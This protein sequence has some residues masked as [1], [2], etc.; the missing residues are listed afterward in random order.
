M[1]RLARGVDHGVADHVGHLVLRQ[2]DAWE[3]NDA[4]KLLADWDPDGILLAPGHAVAVADLAA[5][6]AELHRTHADLRIEMTN[7]IAAPDGRRFALEWD[8]AI[9]ELATR[10]R[11]ITKD[12]IVV[13]LSA[14][15]LIRSWR[16]Y[17]DPANPATYVGTDDRGSG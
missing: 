12:A 8:W 3:T 15:G 9:T 7:L 11:K 4:Q 2:A 13:D 16:E 17:F 6:L 10:R 5:E 1:S 14:G